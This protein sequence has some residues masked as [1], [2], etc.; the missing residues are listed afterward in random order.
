MSSRKAIP[1]RESTDVLSAVADLHS[2]ERVELGLLRRPDVERLTGLARSTIYRDVARGS[3]PR[4]VRLTAR[5]VAWSAAEIFAWID[6]RI[7]TRE[8]QR[9]RQ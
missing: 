1:N 6:E 4:P 7:A 2:S 9:Q 8:S 3:F 5:S